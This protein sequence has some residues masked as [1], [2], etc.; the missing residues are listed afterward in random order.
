MCSGIAWKYRPEHYVLD[1]LNTLRYKVVAS[2]KRPLYI[3]L[4]LTLPPHPTY[5]KGSYR[6]T[7]SSSGRMYSAREFSPFVLMFICVISPF[8]QLLCAHC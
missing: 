7:L 6:N 1:G 5:F 2:E 8:L 3:W 4:Q